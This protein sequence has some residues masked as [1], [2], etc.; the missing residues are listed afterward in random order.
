MIHQLQV[1]VIKLLK[2][3]YQVNKYQKLKETKYDYAICI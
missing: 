1:M 3:N 2:K